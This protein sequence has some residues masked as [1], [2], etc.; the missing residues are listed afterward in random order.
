MTP[1]PGAGSVGKSSPPPVTMVQWCKCW[2]CDFPA[3]D[4]DLSVYR[5]IVYNNEPCSF[6]QVQ[7][8][9]QYPPPPSYLNTASDR[10]TV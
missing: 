1:I 4:A 10:F 3:N 5:F 8:V 2:V 9:G 6:V 7:C